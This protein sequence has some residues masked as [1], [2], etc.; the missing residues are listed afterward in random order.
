[1]I[2]VIQARSAIR[3]IDVF[4]NGSIR[5]LG[6]L[7]G[8]SHQTMMRLK[9]RCIRAD[10]T[11][12]EAEQLTDTEL[13]QKLYPTITENNSYKRQPDVE[14]IVVELT[15]P[16]GKGKTASVLYLEYVGVLGIFPS[17]VT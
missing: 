8:V 13:K 14:Y 9:K 3:V 6:Q 2:P 5:K 11:H 15:K 12:E 10:V 17:K 1:M 7:V 4:P 16:R